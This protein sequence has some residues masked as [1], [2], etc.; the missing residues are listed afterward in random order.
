MCGVR[1]GE[2]PR[3]IK[4]RRDTPSPQKISFLTL[5]EV[6]IDEK[7]ISSFNGYYCS[8]SGFVLSNAS[9]PRLSRASNGTETRFQL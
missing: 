8:N 1:K 5:K 2:Y 4:P 3:A 9:I 6:E 7:D